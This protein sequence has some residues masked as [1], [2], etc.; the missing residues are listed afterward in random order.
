MKKLTFLLAALVILSSLTCLAADKAV[1]MIKG[2]RI[3]VEVPRTE[4]ERNAGLMFRKYLGPNKGMLFVYNR[5]HSL[6]YWMKNTSIPL[7]IA[8]IDKEQRIVSIQK[9]EPLDPLKHY[10]CPVMCKYALEVNQG[11]FE[12]NGIQVGDLVEFQ[13]L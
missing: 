2:K 13:G 12:E 3:S 7:S 5:E 1:V 10:F 4:K 6:S 11:F 8:F 9:M